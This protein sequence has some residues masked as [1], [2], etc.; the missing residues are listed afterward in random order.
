MRLKQIGGVLFFLLVPVLACASQLFT[1]PAGSSVGDGIVNPSALFGGRELGCNLRLRI[2]C[3][4]R[5]VSDL[6]FRAME[7]RASARAFIKLRVKDR[8]QRN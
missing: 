8:G 7:R 6:E 3:R 2:C 5:P 4:I 1:M